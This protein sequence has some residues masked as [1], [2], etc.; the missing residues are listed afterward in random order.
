MS[1]HSG[2]VITFYSFK[3]G[4]GR[5]LALADVAIYLARWGW[6]V[7]CVDWDLEAPG[8]DVYFRPWLPAE[9][10]DGVLELVEAFRDGKPMDQKPLWLPLPIPETEERLHLLRAGR[11]DR[12]YARRIQSIEWTPLYDAKFGM[13]LEQIR[14]EWQDH[15]DFVLID[16]RT[17]LSDIGAI[18]TIQLPDILVALFTPSA[19]SF[20]GA[21]EVARGAAVAQRRVPV[22]RAPLRIV[23][24]LTRAENGEYQQVERWK[25]EVMKAC[26]DLL[27]AWEPDVVV[28]PRVLLSLVVP[29]VP[30]WSFDERLAALSDDA[31]SAGSVGYVHAA[32]AAL[33]AH[34]LFDA[35]GLME[36]RESYLKEVQ[37]A[38]GTAP[39]SP[40][41][42]DAC[43]CFSRNDARF[44][45]AL[46]VG[47]R[48][49][50]VQVFFETWSLIP[51]ADWI[52]VIEKALESV[53]TVLVVIGPDIRLMQ[54]GIVYYHVTR[55]MLERSFKVIPVV[56]GNATVPPELSVSPALRVTTQ[57]ADDIAE[58]LAPDILRSRLQRGQP[59]KINS[60]DV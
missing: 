19:Q 13:Y 44:A 53:T 57:A 27:T 48:E 6:K 46:A 16:S 45:E 15:Y 34:G 41:S 14:G 50:G 8:L 52:A 10:A 2:T 22:D 18:C 38:K 4:V 54:S 25:R 58:E 26:A 31:L 30:Y 40:T 28:D 42:Y 1:S 56:I 47:L 11:R 35:R 29:A 49:R 39:V 55:S 12:T 36:Y 7:L 9:P 17:G 60:S 32:L 23:P 33:L 51:G 43:L 20:E 21:M 3:G 59:E 24:V 37:P 5:T